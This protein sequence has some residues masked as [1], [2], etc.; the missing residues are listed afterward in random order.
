M[1]FSVWQNSPLSIIP[2]HFCC[3]CSFST[4]G[5]T[6][7]RCSTCFT[8]LR[9]LWQEIKVKV[10]LYTCMTQFI[11]AFKSQ[12]MPMPRAST[13]I[14]LDLITSAWCSE[15]RP[16]TYSCSAQLWW[17]S[18]ETAICVGQLFMNSSWWWSLAGE[19]LSVKTDGQEKKEGAIKLRKPCWASPYGRMNYRR[20]AM[21]NV[22]MQHIMSDWSFLYWL[23]WIKFKF[24]A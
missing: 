1:Y 8:A 17:P 12:L 10:M 11:S 21:L 19:D 16:A 6:W 7:L 18:N 14:T 22:R 5:H 13:V 4:N 24:I 15:Q 20:L 23:D 9:T 3:W 2:W